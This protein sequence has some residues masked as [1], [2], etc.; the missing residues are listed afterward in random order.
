MSARTATYAGSSC[1]WWTDAAATTA[2]RPSLLSL[3]APIR[4][5]ARKSR[6]E[7]VQADD[8]DL[9]LA[10]DGAYAGGAPRERSPTL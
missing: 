9:G 10:D 3:L 8:L 6:V 2:E 7:A 1:C 4:D 5:D